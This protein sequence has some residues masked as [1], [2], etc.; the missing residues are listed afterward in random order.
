[1]TEKTVPAKKY[2]DV[3]ATR[4]EDRYLR[5]PVDIFETDDSLV[6]VC[7]MPG[8][9]Q[10]GIDVSIDNGVLTIEGKSSYE[11][12]GEAIYTEFALSNYFRQF[13]LNQDVDQEGITAALKHG[14]LTVAIPK[15][16]R[17]KPKKIAVTIG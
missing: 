6:A 8:V 3:P 4:G 9:S 10:Q 15:S 17:V 1:M 11:P 7:D 16:E 12:V 13:E 5:P 14:V 2:K